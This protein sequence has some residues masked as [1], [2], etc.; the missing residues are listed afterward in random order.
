MHA[1]WQMHVNLHYNN[2]KTVINTFKTR[3]QNQRSQYLNCNGTQ[4]QTQLGNC[5]FQNAYN[6]SLCESIQDSSLTLIYVLQVTF[7]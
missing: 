3:Y 2:A 5:A 4:T 7:D 1:I 6:W